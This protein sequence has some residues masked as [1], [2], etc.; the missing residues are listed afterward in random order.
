M[1]REPVYPKPNPEHRKRVMD[2]FYKKVKETNWQDD[3]E[4]ISKP[5]GR[6]SKILRPEAKLRPCEKKYNW[7]N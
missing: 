5:R 2:N 1:K 4:R 3:E 7:F 6:K